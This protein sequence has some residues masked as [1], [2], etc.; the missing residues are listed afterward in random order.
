MSDPGGEGGPGRKLTLLDAT[1]LV[2]GGIIGVGIFFNPHTIAARVPSAGPYLA[3]W[4]FGGL[5]AIAAGFTFAELGGSFPRAGGWFVYLRAAFGRPVAFVFAWVVL[6]VQSTGAIASIAKFCASRVHILAPGWVG[7]AG[8]TSETVVAALLV[9]SVT[10]VALLG[11][12]RAALVQNLCMVTK[13]VVIAALVAGGLVFVGRGEAIPA[14]AAEPEAARALSTGSVLLALLPLFYTL[15]GW[16]LVG[17]IAPEVKDPVRNVPRAIL[18]GVLGVVLVYLG[19]NASYL[20]VLGIDGLAGDPAFARTLSQRAFG[21]L[22]ERVLAAGMCVSAFGICVVNI[23]ATPWLYVAMAREGLFFEAVGRVEP[24]TGVPRRALLLQ[25]AITCVYLLFTLDFLVDSVVFVEWLFHLLAA[26]GLLLLRA[27]QPELPRP[28]RSPLYP[29][30]PVL[31]LLAACVVVGGT[32]LHPEARFVELPGLRIE[33]RV[34]GLSIVLAGALLY[35]PWRALV[36][37]AGSSA[38][39]P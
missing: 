20:A 30:A 4:V 16:Q 8:S 14:A 28:F 23:I 7:E 11:V 27:R 9:G 5:V 2:M 13:L 1:L 22:G 17:Y 12:K 33:L 3:L 19:V 24:R 39:P 35:R 29:L 32:L 31:Y 15:G 26:A 34:L 10:V 6:T 21:D 36:E 37:R 18:L 25:G 38:G